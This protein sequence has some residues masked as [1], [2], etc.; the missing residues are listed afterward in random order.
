MGAFTTMPAYSVDLIELFENSEYGPALSYLLLTL[1]GCPLL[2]YGGMRIA[3][4]A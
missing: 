4:A 2:A 1:L 3:Q